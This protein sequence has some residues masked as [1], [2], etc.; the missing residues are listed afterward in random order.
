[1]KSGSRGARR[2]WIRFSVLVIVLAIGVMTI[3]RARTAVLRTLGHALVVND[4]ATGADVIVI[5]VDATSAGVLE[6]ADLVRKGVANTVAIFAE[7]PGPAE[8][9]LARRG[10]LPHDRTSRAL[11]QLKLLGVADPIRIPTPVDGTTAEGAV[12]SRWMTERG[13]HNVVIVTTA[14][15]TRRMRRVLRR[16]LKNQ[17]A[18]VAVRAA[19]FSQFNA[20]TW[21]H[22]RTG[23]RTGITELQKLLLDVLSHPLS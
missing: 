13:F 23:I 21:W 19:Q 8:L 5:S 20:D 17:N 18:T 11:E 1:M 9:E 10:I 22:T 15:H 14:D 16:A 7:L 6:A 2:R 3:P 4:S 12:L